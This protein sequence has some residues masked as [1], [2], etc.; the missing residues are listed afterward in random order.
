LSQR[1]LEEISEAWGE[2][3]GFAGLTDTV[4]AR[5]ITI[6]R[7]RPGCGKAFLATRLLVTLDHAAVHRLDPDDDLSQLAVRIDAGTAYVLADPA[8]PERLRRHILQ[9]LEAPL[10]DNGGRLI[11]TMSNDF[12]LSDEDLTGYLLEPGVTPS[13]ARILDGQLRYRIGD[14]AEGVLADSGVLQ[15]VPELLG[16]MP[17]ATRIRDLAVALSEEVNDDGRVNV[18]RV[19]RRF[20]RSADE[21]IGIWF[22]SLPD[23]ETRCLALALAAFDGLPAEYVAEA[24][25]A[26]RNRLEPEP[27]ASVV[28]GDR[29]L[30]LHTRDWFGTTRR[31]RL[32]RLR[33]R[34]SEADYRSPTLGWVPAEL[35]EYRD[36]RYP[37]D[38]LARAWREYGVQAQLLDWLGDIAASHAAETMRIYAASALGYLSTFAFERVQQRV[39]AWA[40]GDDW[41]EWHAAAYTLEVPVGDERL[42]PR[43]LGLV[44]GWYRD[45][46]PERATYQAT[47]ALAYGAVI[48][49]HEPA[50]ALDSLGRL[51]ALDHDPEIRFCVG[52]GLALMLARNPRLTSSIL[53]A[54]I[55]WIRDRD[56]R[57]TGELAFLA[58]AN[59]VMV[60][61]DPEAARPRAAIWP[62]LLSLADESPSLGGGLAAL[63]RLVLISADY[64]DLAE[65]VMRRWARSVETDP[66]G[67]VVLGQL[68]AA[69]CMRDPRTR[70]ILLRQ[71]ELWAS[72]RTLDP[73]PRAAAE[74]RAAV[75]SRREAA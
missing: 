26:L 2:P 65:E 19:R 43:V 9:G 50:L 25:E 1:D 61:P 62:A 8:A 4:R 31:V 41:L 6:L 5:S 42:R 33:A 74:V 56:R 44:R 49:E 16:E 48:A 30:L 40:E 12:Q 67:C 18:E 23:L 29:K 59:T 66:R 14:L 57:A 72:P 46:D 28:V 60:D 54:L 69:A 75:R 58:V 24:A 21:S 22:Q 36:R 17:S 13:A 47:A 34:V 3:D 64:S 37:R 11:V 10:Q 51:A 7:G 53:A 32:G 45:D 38:V 39:Q 52:R 68:A 35:L 55:R 63:W 27:S 71:A 15:L 20:A 70:H 73:T